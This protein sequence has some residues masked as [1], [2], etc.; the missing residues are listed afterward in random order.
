MLSIFD[1]VLILQL[2]RNQVTRRYSSGCIC[3]YGS[4]WILTEKERSTLTMFRIM[5]WTRILEWIERSKLLSNSNHLSWLSGCRDNTCNPLMLLILC[6]LTMMH[7]TFW[8]CA[9]NKSFFCKL[10]LICQKLITVIRKAVNIVSYFILFQFFTT[11]SH[12]LW[13]YS[14]ILL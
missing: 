9:S 10:P 11:S 6:I 1:G 2:T 5:L 13:I 7:S 4:A 14:N 8:N 12:L 3:E